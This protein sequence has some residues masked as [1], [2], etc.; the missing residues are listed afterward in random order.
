MSKARELIGWSF[1]RVFIG[2]YRVGHTKAWII[3]GTEGLMP[4]KQEDSWYDLPLSCACESSVV[5]MH[6]IVR[7]IV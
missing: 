6:G 5:D 7:L 1:D 4:Y 3:P 2:R